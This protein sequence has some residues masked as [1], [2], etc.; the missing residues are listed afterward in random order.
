[1]VRMQQLGG[2]KLEDLRRPAW[3]PERLNLRS[4][5]TL[6]PLRLGSVIHMSSDDE[7]EEEEEEEAEDH[8][9]R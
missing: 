3:S 4:R 8:G 5:S 1:M 7:E 2:A 6:G 9:G